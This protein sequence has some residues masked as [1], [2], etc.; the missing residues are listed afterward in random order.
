VQHRKSAA[1]NVSIRLTAISI[2]FSACSCAA[3]TNTDD[4]VRQLQQEN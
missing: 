3:E 1:L 2:A 4:A